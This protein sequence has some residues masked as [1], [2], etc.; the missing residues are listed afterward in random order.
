MRT[1]TVGLPNAFTAWLPSVRVMERFLREMG[2]RVLT[3]PKTTPGILKTATTI[4][5][6]DFC[7][8]VRVLV[9]HVYALAQDHPDLD[10]IVVPNVCRE[11][12]KAVHCSKY[13]DISGIVIRSIA[14]TVGYLAARAGSR[15]LV[16]LA[17][18]I[19]LETVEASAERGRFLPRILQPEIW[20]ADRERL[21]HACYRLYRDLTRAAGGIARGAAYLPERLRLRAAP[22][23]AACRAAFAR[24]Y[25][26]V[27][28]R[29]RRDLDAL[30][31]DPSRTRLAVLGRSYLH[32]DPLITAD[33]KPYFRRRG[34]DVI[35]PHD[36]PFRLL[37]DGFARTDG[38]YESHKMY[39]AFLDLVADRIDGVVVIGAFG[40]HPDAFENQY[41]LERA[42]ERGLPAWVLKYDEQSSSTGFITRYETILGFLEQRRDQRLRR[43]LPLSPEAVA[44]E[45]ARR[46]PDAGQPAAAG[47]LPPGARPA[48]AADRLPV[49]V[50]P[51]MS[52]I[53]D[54]V[55]EELLHQ[56]GLGG[57]AV[58]PAPLSTDAVEAGNFKF[59]ESCCPYALT[60]GSLILSVRKILQAAEADGRPRRI[61]LLQ[62][63]GDGPCTY[64]W[65]ARM[66]RNELPRVFARD[67]AAGGHTMEML[68][69][70]GGGLLDFIGP[71]SSIGRAERLAPMVEL[72]RAAAQPG[73]VRALPWQKRRRLMR[74]IWRMV[75][76]QR[77]ILTA[78]AMAKLKA[79][80]AVRARTLIVRAHERQKGATTAI[81]RQVCA[82]MHSVHTPSEIA[83]VR[84]RGLAAVEAVDQDGEIKPRVLVVGEIYV[85]LAS[86]ANR[87]TVDTLLG[88]EGIEV[89]EGTTLLEY[90]G[91]ALAGMRRG[92]LV[93]RIRPL[94]EILTGGAIALEAPPNFDRRAS[95]FVLHS[96]GGDG[97]HSV[98]AA[99]DA[100]EH[101][102]VDGIVHL[103][104]FKCM[105]ETMAKTAL[106]E[107][108]Q[109]Y[110]VKYLPLDFDKELD[111][112]RLR[113]EVST[114]AAMLKIHLEQRGTSGAAHDRLVREEGRRRRRLGMTLDR[115]TAAARML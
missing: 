9:G 56:A 39:Q 98:S 107:I 6:A 55:F 84:A 93:G 23:Y 18:Q 20:S 50:W 61:V 33:L 15:D 96:L 115:M 31:R 81:W 58:R 78:T 51:H 5:S 80:E 46:R 99:R 21:F 25:D 79:L 16:D 40:C 106:A 72:A 76:P 101:R 30:L 69:L 112:Q 103:Y 42:R 104:P 109:L 24:A 45:P 83:Q 82:Q 70:G 85:V 111:I 60:T 54:V 14:G 43:P 36:L 95:P 110:G 49:L 91:S 114:F 53:L 57:V 88:R 68:T 100:V 59:S 2:V 89:V 71:L 74:D 64:G 38:F 62:G 19:G 10:A 22:H 34:C 13:R 90:V 67:L 65:Y 11:H 41:F 44:Q 37:E 12:G 73:G 92:A 3:T 32:D 105:P 35:S 52:P 28:V 29:D 77:G 48:T 7:I 86:F 63:R 27:I 113:T 47:G 4:C 17:G 1:W 94:V 26:A 97:R 75:H 102:G 108:A 8:P 87:G 66:Q